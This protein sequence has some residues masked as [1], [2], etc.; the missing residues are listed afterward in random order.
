MSRII[1]IKLIISQFSTPEDRQV[2]VDAF[3][4]GQ[5]GGLAN[6][7]SQMSLPAAY[8]TGNGWL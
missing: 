3:K 1:S 6:A 2:L 4:K 5:S 7:L 8:N